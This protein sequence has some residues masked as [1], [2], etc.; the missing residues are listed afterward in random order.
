MSDASGGSTSPPSA[1]SDRRQS[2]RHIACFPAAL[3]R[4]DGENRPSLIRDLSETGVLLLV[5]TTKIAVGDRVE[6]ELYIS[7]DTGTH[8]R[9][10]GHVVRVEEL[11]P[12]EAGP[13]LRRVAV[14]FDEPLTVYAA[15]IDAF[16][17]RAARLGL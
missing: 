2:E 1:G 13:W 6:L 12:K 8:R 11:N 4:P 7:E 16:R 17:E 15:D 14:Q 9:A 3:E 10:A 5:R